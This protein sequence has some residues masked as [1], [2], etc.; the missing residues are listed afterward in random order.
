M[1]A[2]A[3]NPHQEPPRLRVGEVLRAEV[4]AE[5][6]GLA[7]LENGEEEDVPQ[8]SKAFCSRAS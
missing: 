2:R 5:A 4:L 8:G 1:F 6:L 3:H 7:H